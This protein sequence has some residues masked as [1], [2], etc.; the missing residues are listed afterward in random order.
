MRHILQDRSQETIKTYLARLLDRDVPRTKRLLTSVKH[1]REKAG[2]AI[3]ALAERFFERRVAE[4]DIA[5]ASSLLAKIEG[6]YWGEYGP[7][8][9]LLYLVVQYFPQHEQTWD[10]ITR[11]ARED[12]N[13]GIRQRALELLAR[14]RKEVPATWDLITEHARQDQNAS[15]RQ[16]A[17][18]LL[19]TRYE[20]DHYSR[21][22]LSSSTVSLRRSK[23]S[24]M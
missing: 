13:A 18:A 1:L 22:I 9:T 23:F 7:K 6:R 4:E 2:N 12:Q 11:H 8:A 3:V 17:L 21:I 10:L 16:A 20:L 14:G 15:V 5:F 24:F 19:A